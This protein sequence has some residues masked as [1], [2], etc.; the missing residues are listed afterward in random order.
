MRILYALPA[1]RHDLDDRTGWCLANDLVYAKSRG[2]QV[3]RAPNPNIPSIERIRNIYCKMALERGVD[4]LLMRDA[5]L[6][7]LGTEPAIAD[8]ISKLAGYD[9]TGYRIRCRGKAKWNTNPALTKVGTGYVVIRT[10]FLAK[11]EPPWF[12]RETSPDGTELVT[13]SD[14]YFCLHHK[15]RLKVIT[16]TPFGHR[17]EA[18]LT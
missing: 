4:V 18:V 12:I 7:T 15:P 14:Y 16:D 3:E 11:C 13:G 9:M 10:A 2:W 6:W 1:Y 17:D 8:A 5:D